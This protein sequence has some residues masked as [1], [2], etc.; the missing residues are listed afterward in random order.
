MAAWLLRIPLVSH[1]R[2][3]QFGSRSMKLLFRLPECGGCEQC[4]NKCRLNNFCHSWRGSVGLDQ[5]VCSGAE[6]R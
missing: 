3:D 1:V 5:S 2:G 4:A 6:Q